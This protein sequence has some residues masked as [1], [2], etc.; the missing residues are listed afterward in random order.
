MDKDYFPNFINSSNMDFLIKL[1]H[2]EVELNQYKLILKGLKL[3]QHRINKIRKE[4]FGQVVSTNEKK[5]TYITKFNKKSINFKTQIVSNPDLNKLDK[6]YKVNNRNKHNKIKDTSQDS[7]ELNKI[8]GQAE[9]ISPENHERIK[10]IEM[11]N[12]KKEKKLKNIFTSNF[13]EQNEFYNN[14]NLLISVAV[15]NQKNKNAY[16]C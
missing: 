15:N 4:V 14:E 8:K 7:N 2:K 11:E 6:R 10:E 1:S 9:V 13:S 12:A 3:R 5:V 16:F